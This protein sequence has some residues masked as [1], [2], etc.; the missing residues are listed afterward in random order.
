M[1]AIH[2]WLNETVANTAAMS[3]VFS[4]EDLAQSDNLACFSYSVLQQGVTD[5]LNQVIS[6]LAPV[7]DLF[8]QDVAPIVANLTCPQ[9]D[10]YNVGQFDQFSG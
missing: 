6:G 8:D 7:T 5:F 4:A 3:G 9:L 1:C 2:A 10:S